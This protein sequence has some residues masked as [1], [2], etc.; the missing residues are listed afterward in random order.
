MD[1]AEEV[2]NYLHSLGASC[3]VIFDPEVVHEPNWAIRW[4]QRLVMVLAD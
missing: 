1:L 3:M 2:R 4:H